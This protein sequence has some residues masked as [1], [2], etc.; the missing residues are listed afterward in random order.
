MQGPGPYLDLQN[1]TALNKILNDLFR[2]E[3]LHPTLY[4]VLFCVW[5]EDNWVYSE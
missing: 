1:H 4:L 2:H 3:D 5:R